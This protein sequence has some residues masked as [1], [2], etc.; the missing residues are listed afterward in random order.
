MGSVNSCVFRTSWWTPMNKTAA[1]IVFLMGVVAF[2]VSC[3]T[4]RQQGC[5]KRMKEE[6]RPGTPLESDSQNLRL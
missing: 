3:G 1:T 2:P 6:I 4:G 5:E